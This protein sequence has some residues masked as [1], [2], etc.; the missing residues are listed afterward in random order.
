M[1]TAETTVDAA[2]APP[3][4]RGERSRE[5]PRGG[6]LSTKVLFHAHLV[7][8]GAPLVLIRFIT[9]I[10]AQEGRLRGLRGPG[11]RLLRA[12]VPAAAPG[13]RALI[14]RD[15]ERLI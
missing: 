7:S 14:L 9:D 4:Q 8:A 13:R 11:R 5:A 6:E 12:T 2:H 15:L 1:Q 10:Q 3:Q